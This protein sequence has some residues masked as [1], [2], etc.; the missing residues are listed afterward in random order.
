MVHY[1]VLHPLDSPCLLQ[2]PSYIMLFMMKTQLA[3]QL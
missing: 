2:L 3:L 1:F